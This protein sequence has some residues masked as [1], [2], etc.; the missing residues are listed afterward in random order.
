MGKPME[1]F[2]E[3]FN[4]ASKEEILNAW[5]KSTAKSSKD[6]KSS[7]SSIVDDVCNL[8]LYDSS[9]NRELSL[10]KHIG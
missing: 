5:N 2:M 7:R 3:W 8:K 1:L 10:V 4:S 6:A 9:K